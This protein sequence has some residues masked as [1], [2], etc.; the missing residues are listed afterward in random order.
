[1]RYWL[2]VF[3]LITFSAAAQTLPVLDQN[4]PSLPWYQLRTPHFRVLY[5]K[6]FDQ[7]AQQT[8][9]RLEQVYEPVSASL[10]K[11]PRR[12]SVIL[13]N[14]TMLSNGFVT[15]LPRRS[16]FF[17]T[18]PQDPFLAGTLGWLDLL[19]VHEF[20]HVV[21]Y[22]KALQGL[23]RTA[24]TLF[25]NTALAALTLGVPDWFWEGDAVG[26]ESVLTGEGRGRIPNFDLGMRANLLAGRRFSYAK[27][28]NGSYRD[29]VPNHYV[30]GYFMST[31]LKRTYGADAWSEVLNRYYRFPLYPFSFSNGIKKTT[32]Y[33]VEELYRRS[34]ADVEETWR[35][36]QQGLRLTD[37][38]TYP[39]KASEKVFTNYQ[40]PQYVSEHEVIAVKSGLGDITQFVRLDRN[41]KETKVFVPGLFNN[42]EMLSVAAGKICWTEYRY[43]VRF[44]QKI[45]SEIKLY[46]VTTQKLRR[47]SHHSR[48]SVASLSPDGSRV[49]AVRNDEAYQTRLVILDAETGREVRVLDNPEND[50]FG[51]PRWQ[52]DNRTLV[53]VTRKKAGK[54]IQI[55]DSETGVRRDLMPVSGQN[56]SHPQPWKG[57]V[58]YNSPQSGIDNIYVLNTRTGR[59]YQVTSRPLGAYHPTVS[60]DGQKLSFHDFRAGGYRIAEMPIDSSAWT[61]TE[62]VRDG[63]VRYFGPLVAQEPGAADVRSA[64]TDSLV[65]SVEYPK[66]R[67]SRLLHAVNIYSWGPVVSSD[68]Q[69]GTVGLQSQ[70]LLS[71]TQLGLGV[72]YNQA[73]RTVNYYG[74]LSYQG[75][76]PI[77]DVGFERGRRSTSVYV[78]QRTPLDS[79]R[80]DSW[81]Y[82]QLTAGFRIPLQLTTSK[83]NQS[84]YVSAYYNLQQV[85]GYDLPVRPIT[86]VGFGRVLNGLSYGL[87]YSRTLKLSK[88]DVAPRWGQTVSAVWR[89]TPF[90]GALRG[91]VWAL[92]GGLYLPGVGKHH[93]LRLRAGYQEQMR[94]TYRFAAAVFF[95]RGQSYVSH[96]QLMTTSAEYRLPLLNPHWSI[97]RWLYIQRVKAAGFYDFAWG[98]SRSRTPGTLAAYGD[99]YYTTGLD[100][101]FVFNVLRLRTPL[102]AGVR[103]IYNLKSG[104]VMVQPLVI[105]IGI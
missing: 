44:G 38:V 104:E 21:Q 43:D 6:G 81:N 67:F 26:T 51:Q 102:E 66:S 100:L 22:D 101:S 41:G 73:E 8:A 77:L 10:K 40:Y 13:Q 30:L 68:G 59:T 35:K 103:T 2:P 79:L 63:S 97:G 91:E 20:R 78:D 85:S 76:F 16:E 24:Y 3:L 64:L 89:N 9:R 34:M 19:A 50:F 18:P 95:P 93:S 39:V 62:Q 57:Y 25:G 88:R 82:N 80:S 98:E 105:G 42:P 70:D 96:D 32:Q 1:M 60:G 31:Y 56:I 84:A 58:F 49:V 7:T 72:G 12:L 86:E 55:I 36:Q 52:D 74:N 83:Y 46:D 87:S 53:V 27:A 65:A 47:L 28:V 17:A 14:Q 99:Q 5:P 71:T 29:N 33:R 11:E 54:T 75:W 90:G 94:G 61:P 48:Y 15:L 45:D 37:A 69:S 23:T 92:Q 4:P